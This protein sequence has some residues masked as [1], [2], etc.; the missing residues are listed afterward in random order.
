C[1]L[2][3]TSMVSRRYG[4][5]YRFTTLPNVKGEPV[6]IHISWLPRYGSQEMFSH[7][8]HVIDE[9]QPRLVAMI[10]ICAGDKR[11]VHLGDLV[12][13]ER[14]F[15]YDSGKVVKG[16]HGQALYQQDMITYQVHENTLGFLRLFEHWKPRVAALS[17]PLSK[18]QQR[19]WLLQRLFEE[20]T[21]SVEAIPLA[22]REEFAPAWQRLVRELQQG[23]EPFLSSVWALH[24][25]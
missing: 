7:L 21:G 2:L 22:E 24:D 11:Y 1:N 5:D 15:A 6:R 25:K 17:R 13:A 4:Y 16:E 14:T 19:D 12:V 8:G 18:Q 3:W 10:G 20:P 23:R 9:Y